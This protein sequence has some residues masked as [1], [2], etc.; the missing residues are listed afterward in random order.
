MF[1]HFGLNALN[2]HVIAVYPGL[3]SLSQRAP[4]FYRMNFSRQ[5]YNVASGALYR[6]V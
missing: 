2:L 1:F 4:D 6:Q 5:D 3:D